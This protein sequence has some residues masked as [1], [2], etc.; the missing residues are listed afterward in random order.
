MKSSSPVH[1]SAESERSNGGGASSVHPGPTPDHGLVPGEG[2]GSES[3]KTRAASTDPPTNRANA[4]SPATSLPPVGPSAQEG[5]PP[6][7][8]AR[9]FASGHRSGTGT[10][11]ASPRLSRRSV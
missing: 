7:S 9:R 4:T 8:P 1:A 3:R 11:S 6:G 5:G 10:L 2:V